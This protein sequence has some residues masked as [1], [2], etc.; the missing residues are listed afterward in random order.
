MQNQWGGPDSADKRDW[1]AGAIAEQFQ[2]DTET[3][4]DDVADML[5]QVMEDEFEVV[6]D[7]GSE[8]PVAT[9]V[10]QIRTEV[11]DGDFR[12]VDNML[13]KWEER[14]DKPA[15]MVKVHSQSDGEEESVD[16]EDWEDDGDT[17]MVD[18]P[19]LTPSAPK[20]KYPPEVDEDGFTKVVGKKRR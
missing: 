20:S 2:K 10:I 7:D 16:D 8:V 11:R 17:E 4:G 14:K 12:T 1:L 18:A 6:V 5:L 9:K 19:T 13:A 3:D 15:P